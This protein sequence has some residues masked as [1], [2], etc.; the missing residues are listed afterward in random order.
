MRYLLPLLFVFAACSSDPIP[1]GCTPGAQTACACPG[2][3]SSVQLCT[4][5]GTLGACACSDG[6]ALDVAPTVDAGALDAPALDVPAIVDAPPA[7]DG[8]AALPDGC[9]STTAGNCCGVACPARANATPGCIAGA[10][11]V[12]ACLPGFGDCNGDAVD[13]CEVELATSAAHCGACRAACSSDR[14]CVG[15]SCVVCPDLRLACGGAC[16]D[17]QTDPAHC[18]A[19]N[20][21][22]AVRPNA[23][24]TCTNGGCGF[25]C[26]AGTADCDGDAANGCESTNTDVMNCGTCGNRCAPGVMCID[27]RC[28]CAPGRAECDGNPATVC[29]TNTAAGDIAN[30]GGCAMACPMPP[31]GTFAMCV[32]G[33]CRIGAV[34]CPPGFGNCD[35]NDANGCEMTTRDNIDNCGAG[36][37]ASVGCGNVCPRTGGTASCADGVCGLACNTARGDCDGIRGNGCETNT[38]TTAAHCGACDRRCSVPNGTAGCAA[39]ACTVGACSAGYRNCNNVVTDGCEVNVNTDRINCGGCGTVCERG[40]SNGTCAP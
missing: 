40:C 27:R 31:P 3:A 25:T 8:P 20:A 34:T 6:G 17:P 1:P 24:A 21:P 26:E 9:V 2:G 19:C 5:A 33:A 28:G 39:G 18:G 23:R 14:T 30:C 10:C 15:S 7:V 16:V 4:T 29:E 35:G 12:G 32:A 37:L 22:C 11:G 13:G 36:G 38:A